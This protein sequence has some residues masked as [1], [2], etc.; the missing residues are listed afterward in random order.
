L[1][2][3]PGAKLSL[4]MHRK[5]AEHW[6]VVMGV[7]TAIN[8]EEVLTLNKGESTYIPL[9]VTHAI[10]NKTREPLEIIE[11]QSGIYLG[12]DDIV[13]FEDI[14]GRVKD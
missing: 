14:Y 10:E 4:Q 9:G 5:R 11:V 3:N 13:R 2:I 1:H 8:G 7:A 6:V 12:E